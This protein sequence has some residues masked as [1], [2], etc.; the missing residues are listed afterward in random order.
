MSKL[1][2]GVFFLITEWEREYNVDLDDEA[3]A[4]LAGLVTGLAIAAANSKVAEVIK[5]QTDAKARKL[6]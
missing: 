1:D 5:E 6:M 3:R 2:D 4:G